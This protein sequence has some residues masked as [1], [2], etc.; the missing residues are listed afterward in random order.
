MIDLIENNSIR[1]Q[2][3]DEITSILYFILNVFFFLFHL[4]ISIF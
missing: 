4:L 1:I 2:Y 3:Y